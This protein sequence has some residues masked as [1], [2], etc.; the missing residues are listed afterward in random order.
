MPKRAYWNSNILDHLLEV[1]CTASC[2]LIA[3]SILLFLRRPAALVPLVIG[4]AG[5]LYFTLFHFL[6]SVRHDGLIFVLLIAAFWIGATATRIAIPWPRV[7]RIIKTLEAYGGPLLI[8][9]LAVQAVAGV[10]SAVAD[11]FL[12]FTAGKEVGEFVRRELPADAVLVGYEDYTAMTLGYYASRPIYS[13][14][15]KAQGPFFT[16]DER[17][18]IIGGA[19]LLVAGVDRLLKEGDRDVVVFLCPHREV[20]LTE[21]RDENPDSPVSW[22]LIRRFDD[23][24]IPDE[25]TAVYRVRRHEAW[26]GVTVRA[27]NGVR[28]S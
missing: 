7:A 23:S 2:L 8:L 4:S 17:L 24:T 19:E 10:G 16:Q 18:R 12:P 28:A 20:E 21:W 9:L 3:T 13:V 1:R 6:G 14:Q 11:H 5:L 27:R 25:C 26:A 15:V 22:E